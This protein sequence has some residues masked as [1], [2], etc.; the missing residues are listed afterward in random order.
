MVLGGDTSDAVGS[1]DIG[2]ALTDIETGKVLASG[3]YNETNLISF[4][5][6]LVKLL[7][8][9]PK[10]VFIIERRSSAVVIIDYIVKVLLSKN[11]DPFKRL[12]NW[13][14]QEYEDY[15]IYKYLFFII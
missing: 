3:V 7:L 13:V 8:R 11:I 9:F 12:F 14:V 1:D 4:A 6:W 15:I 10:M 2:L 5:M